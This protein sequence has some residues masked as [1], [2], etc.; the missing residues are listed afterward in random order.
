MA[1][2]SAPIRAGRCARVRAPERAALP[3][4]L[5]RLIPDAGHRAL[6]REARRHDREAVGRLVDVREVDH[7]REAAEQQAVAGQVGVV[8]VPRLGVNVRAI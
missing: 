6:R 4:L 3:R 2:P 1:S 7:H 8:A 5:R